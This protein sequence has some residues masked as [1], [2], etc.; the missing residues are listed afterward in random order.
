MNKKS[1]ESLWGLALITPSTLRLQL[2]N[3]YVFDPLLHR[4]KQSPSPYLKQLLSARF[5]DWIVYDRL[6]QAK[7]TGARTAFFA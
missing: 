6:E 4:L 3:D 1:L 7:K 5:H 2:W